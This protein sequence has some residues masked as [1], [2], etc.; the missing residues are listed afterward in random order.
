MRRRLAATARA[1][2]LHSLLFTSATALFLAALA[3]A[4]SEWQTDRSGYLF[5]QLVA[6]RQGA[7]LRERDHHAERHAELRCRSSSHCSLKM[8]VMMTV[9]AGVRAPSISRL[10]AAFSSQ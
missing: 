8:P 9:S 10:T 3:K 5:L 1:A 7:P 4:E 2:A 6:R